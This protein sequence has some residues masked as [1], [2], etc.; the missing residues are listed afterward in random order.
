MFHGMHQGLLRGGEAGVDSSSTD[1]EPALHLNCK[2]GSRAD[3]EASWQWL[4][5]AEFDGVYPVV[6][7]LVMAIKD[8]RGH[9][10]AAHRR[11]YPVVIR[12]RWPAGVGDD[13]PMCAYSALAAVRRLRE[14]EVPPDERAS[15]PFFATD[16]GAP[17]TTARVRE[18]VRAA[19]GVLGVA[20]PEE[21][22]AK[23]LRAGG[24]TDLYAVLGG[25][26]AESLI[27]SRGRWCSEIWQIYARLSADAQAR[28]SAAMTAVE[29]NDLEA[30]VAGWVQPAATRLAR[31]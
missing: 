29:G 30:V 23:A 24:A 5:A 8:A 21:Y 2:V 20:C 4:S 10:D 7:M 22:G 11:R 6:V 26:E 15:A 12:K 3:A 14:A 25:T 31:R 18:E 28:V 27:R 1:F 17:V 13:D 9:D 16:G 19:V